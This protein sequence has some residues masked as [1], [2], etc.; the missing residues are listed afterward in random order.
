M[1]KENSEEFYEKYKPVYNHLEEPTYKKGK[2]KV[3]VLDMIN[4]LRH[5]GEIL[6]M[7][8]SIMTI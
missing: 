5:T 4:T 1:E 7:S 6:S 2:L 3:N 8:K